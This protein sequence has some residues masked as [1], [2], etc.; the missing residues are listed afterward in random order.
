VTDASLDE[1]EAL[2]AT[3]DDRTGPSITNP[4]SAPPASP[5]TPQLRAYQQE[6]VDQIRAHFANGV[7]RICYQLP[8]G[9]GKTVTFAYIIAAAAPATVAAALSRRHELTPPS[10]I[11]V[12]RN[13]AYWQ[14][15]TYRMLQA[16]VP[17]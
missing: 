9:G 6:G 2:P 7:S 10:A 15:V 8:T 12:Q 5:N 14:V 13:G 1:R 16:V 4:A 11:F 17:A 3:T